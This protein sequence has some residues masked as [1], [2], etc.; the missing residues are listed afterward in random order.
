MN[1]VRR[2]FLLVEDDEGDVFLLER[3][4]QKIPTQNPVQVVTDGEMAVAYL[5][6]TGEF[7]DRSKFPIPS[8]VFLDLKLP[9][10][11][12]FEV[13]RWILAT[14]TLDNVPVVVLTSS[15]EQRDRQLAD[16]LG[17]RSY[18]VKPPTGEMLQELLA[19]FEILRETP[20]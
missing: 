7:A 17:A 9:F 2:P 19:S 1:S 11:D 20:D 18:L 6:G 12:G 13:L 10:K 8:V 15:D 3:A 14:P 4:L 16:R 5:S